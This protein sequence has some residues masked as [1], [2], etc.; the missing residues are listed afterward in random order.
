[1]VLTPPNSA[2]KSWA[3]SQAKHF[4][5]TQVWTKNWLDMAEFTIW[6]NQAGGFYVKHNDL[7]QKSRSGFSVWSYS[8]HPPEDNER[9]ET[10]WNRIF[11]VVQN[12]N[13]GIWQAYDPVEVCK[14]L[15]DNG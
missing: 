14:E 11:D 7:T 1:M 5:M 4:T 3:N 10:E 12:L 9:F 13:S 2:K 8:E 6:T 15:L